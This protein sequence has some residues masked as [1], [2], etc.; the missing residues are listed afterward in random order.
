MAKVTVGKKRVMH[1]IC[2]RPVCPKSKKY[3][4]YLDQ[5]VHQLRAYPG[6][7]FVVAN[8]LAEW[9]KLELPVNEINFSQDFGQ[10]V[11]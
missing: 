7:K 3:F 9:K 11:V 4:A 5:F 1:I 8:T 6:S 2:L 10:K